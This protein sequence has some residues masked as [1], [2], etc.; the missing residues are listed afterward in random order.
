MNQNI[1]NLTA[2]PIRRQLF[3]LALPV[4]GTSFIQM[5]YS[6]TDMAWVG[7]LGS[8]AVAA[9]GAVGILTWTTNSIALLNKVGSEV[10]VSQSIG[11][12]DLERAS[13]LATH[14]LTMA[15]RISLVWTLLL[16]VGAPF[17]I[18]LFGLTS[19]VARL[20]VSYLRI[21][22][23]AFPFLFLSAAMTGIYNAAG[24]TRI[25]FRINS[26]G[27]LA[28]MILDPVFIHLFQWHTNGAAAATALSQLLVCLL[29]I[30]ALRHRHPLFP[31]FVFFLRRLR[32]DYT[33]MLFRLGLP[34]SLLN[35]FFSLIN[36]FLARVASEYGG[37][38]GV[39]TLTA[40]G[41]LE[42]IAW[43][44]A[45]G[46]STALS[47]FTAQN[48]AARQYDRMRSGYYTTLKMISLF[49]AG[50][51]L[52]FLLGGE[53]LFALIV[54]EPE[55]CQAGGLYLQIDAYSMLFMTYEIT[56]QG[57][58]YGISRTV[59]PAVT[60]IT[61]NTLRIPLALCL[62]SAGLGIAGVW[63]AISLSSI[64]K[65]IVAGIWLYFVWKKLVPV[66][67]T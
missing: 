32:P 65:G 14:N 46:F 56:T 16:F 21:V 52:L 39:M 1:R 61:L 27:L 11:M 34:V 67:K 20:S 40:G 37:H 59:P 42:A 18:S 4:M 43:Y 55:A 5:A 44:T 23:M 49:G 9:I 47:T 10:S 62:A 35:T 36:L 3:Q 2:G 13:C 26:I 25:P 50:C 60:S 38:L 12:N 22:S 15:L 41:Q 51:T 57:F 58:F 8:K 48:Y 54:S 24:Q 63:W 17:F 33:R 29:F 45:Q 53:Q 6:F 30:R 66:K 19:D 31:S 7:S 64:T 28:N